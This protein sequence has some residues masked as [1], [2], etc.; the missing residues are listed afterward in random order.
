MRAD[1]SVQLHNHSYFSFLDAV[2]SP[3]QLA[4][5]AARYEMPAVGLTDHHGLTGAVEFSRACE[6]RGVQPIFGLDLTIHHR[7]ASGS[8]VLLA[9]DL[10]GWGSLCRISTLLQ[11][12]SHRD[13]GRGLPFKEFCSHTTGLLCLTG[14]RRSPLDRLVQQRQ[15]DLA[16]DFLTEI[17]EV[18]PH[19]LYVE[20]HL[21]RPSDRQRVDTLAALAEDSGLPVV[22]ANNAHFLAPGDHHLH[23][24]LVA[25]RTGGSIHAP[26]DEEVVPEEAYF[27]APDQMAARFRDFPAAL[28]ATREVAGRCAVTLPLGEPHYPALALPDGRPAIEVLRGRAQAG[29]R[30]RYGAVTGEIEARL[31][32][33]LGIIAERGY[34]PLFLIMAEILDYARAE[35]VPTASRGSA[36][37]SLV[38]HCL[39]ITTPDP[40]AHN[41]YFERFLNPARRSPPDIDTDLCSVRRE[42]VL[43]HVYSQYGA[44]RVAM[45][46]TINRLRGRSALREVAKAYGL[47]ESVIKD[48]VAEIPYRGWGPRSD[49]GELPYAELMARFPQHRQLFEDAAAVLDFPRHLSIHPGGIVIA[50]GPLTDLLPLHLASKG[51]VITQFDL[52]AVQEMGLVKLD[53]LGTRGLSVLGDVAEKVHGWNR[54]E[55]AA[56]LDVLDA[57]QDDDPQ[58]AALVGS[59]QTIGCFQIESPGMRA[60][61]REVQARTPKD[62]LIA[63]AL[64]RPGPMTGGLKDAFVRRHLGLEPVRHLHPALGSLLA[65]T[66]GV[67]LY[68]E[69]VLRIASELAGLTLADGDLLRRAMSHFDPGEQM[70]TLKARFLE[71]AQQKS[72]VEPAVGEKIWDLMAAFAGYGFPKAHAASYAQV[73]WQSAWCKA[74][75][76]AEFMAAVLANW[77][78]YYRQRVYLNEARRMGLSLRPP[79]IQH[80]GREFRAAYPQGEPVLYMGLN[81]V[82]DLTRKTQRRILAERPFRSLEDFLTRVDPRP[83]EI[84]NLVRIGGLAGFGTIPDLL[85]RVG[86]GGWRHGQ[87]FLFDLPGDQHAEEDWPLA[88]RIEA[89][90][91]ILGAAVDA[92]PLELLP[93]GAVAGSGAEPISEA[94]LR[95]GEDVRVLG[96]RQTL[97]RFFS[98]G[99]ARYVL[100]LEDLTGV[101]PVVLNR[102]QHRRYRPLLQGR[103][104][105]VVSGRIELDPTWHEAILVPR[106]LDMLAG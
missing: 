103:E 2:P 5:A 76:P 4:D 102:E 67:I 11:T 86:A 44:E 47:E 36:A 71:G 37:S 49:D 94:V 101:V 15:P 93:V 54:R 61:L 97:Q 89:Q 68:Q 3:T 104:A 27:A 45:V 43:R 46:A 55:F 22:A 100:E 92:H 53:L 85:A 87:P 9:A 59:T 13:P 56:P 91:S 75:H 95:V 70:R 40:L 72:S 60:T 77:G 1:M 98:A 99:E 31:T 10:A 52:E 33:E 83:Q 41:L 51:L 88:R 8:I 30:K 80:S 65:D 19:R 26:P 84:E 64:Y 34:A 23:R 20:L 81:Q 74:H 78:G 14:G 28:A 25:M 24:L 66:Y 32:H 96:M 50:P 63:L 18:F 106:R 38:A 39:G 12:A 57:I 69:Q 82:R 79:H 90:Q 105:I 62:I 16:A 7:L 73:A 6:A 35:G 29:A 42:K 21:H 17:A 58:T 48:M